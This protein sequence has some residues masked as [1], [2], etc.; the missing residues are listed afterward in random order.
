MSIQINQHSMLE[1][2]QEKLELLKNTI[3][4]GSTDDELDLFVHICKRLGL[5]PFMKQIYP[6]KRWDSSLKK[7]VMAI[8]TGIDGYRL[9]AER[10][11]KYMPG[12]QPTFTYDEQNRLFSATSYVKKLGPD[13]QW[14]EIAATAIYTEYYA[15]TKEGQPTPMWRDKTHLMLAKCAESAALRRAFPAE[16]SGV[17]TDEEMEQAE[18]HHVNKH[19]G[20]IS[21][22]IEV[23]GPMI[24]LAEA[25]NIE[26]IIGFDNEEYRSRILNHYNAK[27]FTEIEHK[28]HDL[29]LNKAKAFRD[30]RAKK[31]MEIV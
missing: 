12:K 29:I 31:E 1:F 23:K 14:H 17:Y 15:K 7:E 5:D 2:S 9:I 6:V 21:K 27:E 30:E 24:T 10:S 18:T 4:K 26:Q 13:G 16:M 25:H 8:Q 3:C 11:G 19:T 20:E 22:P 28:H